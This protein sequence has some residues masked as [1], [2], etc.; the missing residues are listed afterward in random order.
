MDNKEPE[1][2]CITTSNRSTQAHNREE[3]QDAPAQGNPASPT[4]IVAQRADELYATILNTLGIKITD[5]FVRWESIFESL[6][7]MFEPKP[8]NPKTNSS[9][10]THETYT[11]LKIFVFSLMMQEVFNGNLQVWRGLK[12][13]RR[14]SDGFTHVDRN[15]WCYKIDKNSWKYVNAN[16]KSI[17]GNAPLS[18]LKFNT[19][20][21]WVAIPDSQEKIEF[22]NPSGIQYGEL[23]PLVEKYI[24]SQEKEG[25]V[26]HSCVQDDK[27]KHL[28]TKHIYW[29]YDLDEDTDAFTL[30]NLCKKP[31]STQ[32]QSIVIKKTNRLG[33][34][35]IYYLNFYFVLHNNTVFPSCNFSELNTTFLPF[36][37]RITAI[38]E[39]LISQTNHE[40]FYIHIEGLF[41]TFLLSHGIQVADSKIFEFRN[42][43]ELLRKR[44]AIIQGK[45]KHFISFFN[46]NAFLNKA[47]A[48]KFLNELTNEKLK[49]FISQG[50]AEIYPVPGQKSS[51]SYEQ[52]EKEA[53]QDIYNFNFIYNKN[54]T[55]LNTQNTCTQ[56][57]KNEYST[58]HH[59]HINNTY[60]NSKTDKEQKYKVEND[61]EEAMRSWSGCDSKI[62]KTPEHKKYRDAVLLWSTN[63]VNAAQLFEKIW[64]EEYYEDPDKNWNIQ[65][66]AKKIKIDSFAKANGL[67]SVPK[68][69]DKSKKQS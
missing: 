37:K 14:G 51:S 9:Y 21:G 15:S 60:T 35:T 65:W 34:Q 63:K 22:E 13:S 68:K 56:N 39:K 45:I 41:Y 43:P 61:F 31:H 4:S 6:L 33:L 2:P 47:E 23:K 54:Y 16:D 40:D 28:G 57:I 48:S 18:D 44:S 46:K 55:Y 42:K 50:Q 32:R 53:S 20:A 8:S 17:S 3:E 11:D 24:D 52:Q 5:E 30:Q 64:P 49:E 69:T 62:L 66:Q 27:H 25:S 7:K 19:L 1:I 58:Q 38:A 10:Y 29:Q 26:N 67:I 12:E 59:T 36:D